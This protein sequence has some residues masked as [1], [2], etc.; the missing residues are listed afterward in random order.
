MTTELKLGPS[1]PSTINRWVEATEFDAGILSGEPPLGSDAC[2][3]ASPLP[4][5]DV[6]FQGRPVGDALGHVTGKD[7]EL[8]LGHIEPGAVLGR[9]MDLEPSGEPAV[10]QFEISDVADRN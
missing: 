2:T 8:D 5:R 1:A 9:M 7:A 4:G 3:V 6:P 10:G